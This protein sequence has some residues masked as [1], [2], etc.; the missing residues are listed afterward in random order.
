[1]CVCVRE[2]E[3][4]RER[5]VAATKL[6]CHPRGLDSVLRRPISCDPPSRPGQERF[7]PLRADTQPTRVPRGQRQDTAPTSPYSSRARPTEA[8]HTRSECKG[9]PQ[10]TTLRALICARLW[11]PCRFLRDSVA[12]SR[13]A[14]GGLTKGAFRSGHLRGAWLAITIDMITSYDSLGS[15]V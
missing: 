2:R 15:A 7:P 9:G 8:R 4:E 5:D 12:V 6:C 3:R 11:P 13:P 10:S 1:M 14:G